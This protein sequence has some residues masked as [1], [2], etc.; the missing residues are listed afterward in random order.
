MKQKIAEKFNFWSYHDRSDGG[1]AAWT[2]EEQG[3]RG[4]S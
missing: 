1:Q 4:G 3:L 2:V